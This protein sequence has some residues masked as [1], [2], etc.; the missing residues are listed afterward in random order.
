MVDASE[1]SYSKRSWLKSAFEKIG[2]LSF[3]EVVLRQAQVSSTIS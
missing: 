3:S 1:R 2:C